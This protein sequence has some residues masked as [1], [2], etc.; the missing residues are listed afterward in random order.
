M[1][2][3]DSSIF[4]VDFSMP[5]FLSGYALLHTFMCVILHM[6]AHVCTCS[7]LSVCAC[8]CLIVVH[9]EC[10][11]LRCWRPLRWL[12]VCKAIDVQSVNGYSGKL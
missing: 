12:G 5:Y 7:R 11:L 4:N 2:H 6:C 8:V 10:T 3:F 1:S 9:V